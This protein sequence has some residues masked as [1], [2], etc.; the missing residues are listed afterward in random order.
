MF[1]FILTFSMLLSCA[2]GQEEQSP[3]V[4]TELKFDSNGTALEDDGLRMLNNFIVSEEGCYELVYGKPSILFTDVMNKERNYM[5]IDLSVEY[6]DSSGTSWNLTGKGRMNLLAFEDSLY[7]LMDGDNY[8]PGFLYRVDLDGGEHEKIVEIN[9]CLTFYG[10]QA[11]A[12][13]V[14]Y[15][16]TADLSGENRLISINI[17][18]K[19]V[20]ELCRINHTQAYIQSAFDDYLIIQAFD[21][22]PAVEYSDYE[23]MEK[24]REYVTYCY[25]LKDETLSE[26]LCWKYKEQIVGY[27]G[28]YMYIFDSA[29][30]CL[31]VRD[32]KTN[33]ETV[34]IE[35]FSRCGIKIEDI[36]EIADIYDNKMIISCIKTRYILDLNNLEIKKMKQIGYMYPQILATYGDQYLVSADHV[37]LPKDLVD[38]F[39]E[40]VQVFTYLYN[41]K[42][43]DI[44]DFWNQK[45]NFDDIDNIFLENTGKNRQM[46]LKA[47]H[48]ADNKGQ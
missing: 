22:P 34:L 8:V 5:P 46:G 32:M 33:T 12:D 16:M 1:L 47:I 11:G 24:R 2:K 10:C 27:E 25:S 48:G 37:K 20:D 38:R 6:I 45:Y 15:M 43:I 4:Q 31:K 3:D 17:E 30:D 28:Q 9:D 21:E 7:M 23:E 44:A 19:Y 39:G 41:Y 36:D 29:N 35:E 14:L 40:P 13:G 26:I 42:L 18:Q